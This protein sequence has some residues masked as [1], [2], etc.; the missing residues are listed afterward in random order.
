MLSL[1]VIAGFAKANDHF[2]R[3]WQLSGIY[4]VLTFVLG[5][6]FGLPAAWG[7]ALLHAAIT[8]VLVGVL[9]K[10]LY[11]Y[12]DTIFTWLLLLF[13]G[14]FLVGIITKVLMGAWGTL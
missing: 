8:F 9:L 13:V 5:L 7:V 4:V 1:F 12:Q 10:I 2:N 3:P 6:V 11:N 14:I